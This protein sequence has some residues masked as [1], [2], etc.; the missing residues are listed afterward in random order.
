[1]DICLMDSI[2]KQITFAMQ[3]TGVLPHHFLRLTEETT[4]TSWHCPG[5]DMN[6]IPAKY[7]SQALSLDTASFVYIYSK[8]MWWWWFWYWCWMVWCSKSDEL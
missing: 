2:V 1:M 6:W 7:K 4:E 3:G 8:T 5:W